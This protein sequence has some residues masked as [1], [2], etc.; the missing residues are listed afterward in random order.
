M[1]PWDPP[2][3]LPLPAW[4]WLWW[5][6]RLKRS[7]L[8]ERWLRGLLLPPELP[9]SYS[10]LLGKGAGRGGEGGE[11]LL[12]LCLGRSEGRRLDG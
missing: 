2:P 12:V 3:W 10:G 11:A 6:W 9:P 4:W 1:L 8:S 7:S 5:L